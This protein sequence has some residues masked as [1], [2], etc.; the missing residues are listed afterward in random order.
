MDKIM[1]FLVVAGDGDAVPIQRR[2]FLVEP[3][4]E[5]PESFWS[6]GLVLFPFPAAEVLFSC[7]F[8]G[9]FVEGTMLIL[10]MRDVFSGEDVVVAV[11][12]VFEVFIVFIVQRPP[13]DFADPSVEAADDR[14]VAF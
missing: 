13:D 1:I 9:L 7:G 2:L 10:E 4:P 11:A 14:P 6:W 3:L 5:F 12:D 8:D